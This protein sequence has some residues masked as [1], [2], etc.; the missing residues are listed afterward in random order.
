MRRLYSAGL[1]ALVGLG[2]AASP[3]LSQPS[4]ASGRESV[5]LEV[6]GFG[7]ASG[8]L[9]SSEL[10]GAF[11]EGLR[12]GGLR[13]IRTE[14]G[15]ALKWLVGGRVGAG[16]GTHLLVTVDFL[17][18]RIANPSFSGTVLGRLTNIS[19]RMTFLDYTGGV[20]YM[21]STRGVA[22]YLAAGFGVVRLSVSADGDL[23][24]TALTAAESDLTTNFGGGVRLY[25]GPS[26]GLQPDFRIV[27]VPD[28]T[29][30]RT[31]VGVFYQIR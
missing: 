2:F 16:V 12:I 5:A 29:F 24:T 3:A 10:A 19:T 21:F 4:P 9:P 18:N 22:P 15:D 7:G 6:S 30:F 11:A 17:L 1:V 20:Q 13:N 8:G 23:L 25:L 26:W 31:S 14:P 27:T 28:E